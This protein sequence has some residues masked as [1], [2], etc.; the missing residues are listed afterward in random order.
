M[1]EVASIG[2]SDVYKYIQYWAGK[3]LGKQWLT[4]KFVDKSPVLVTIS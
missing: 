2:I 3:P 4:L 1:K